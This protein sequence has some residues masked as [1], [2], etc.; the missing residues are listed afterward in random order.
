MFYKLIKSLLLVFA[1]CA[2][3]GCVTLPVEMSETDKQ[4]YCSVSQF[5][6]L[7]EMGF[8]AK[9]ENC[10]PERKVELLTAYDD[11]RILYHK[12]KRATE[13]R[14]EISDMNEDN[15]VIADLS[16]IKTVFGGDAPTRKK[17]VELQK[18]E[19]EIEETI[20]NAP[21]SAEYCKYEMAQKNQA[22]NVIPTFL[23]NMS[24]ETKMTLNACSR[25]IR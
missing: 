13:L 4:T 21:D 1:T 14:K 11:G 12:K 2:F 23:L 18:V 22:K 17:E 16:R 25:I 10:S 20:K 6:F 3:Q 19:S 8:P 24:A 15:S 7:G 5:Y 9:L